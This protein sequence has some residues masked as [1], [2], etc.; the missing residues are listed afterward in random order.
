MLLGALV[1]TEPLTALTTAVAVCSGTG[2]AVPLRPTVAVQAAATVCSVTA[3]VVSTC[4]TALAA[5]AVAVITALGDA[6]TLALSSLPRRCSHAVLQLL[7]S[8]QC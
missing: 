8:S 3:A 5:A 4:Q 6:A 1:L 7:Y 2:G